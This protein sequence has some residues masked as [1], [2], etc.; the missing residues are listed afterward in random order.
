MRSK[1][2]EGD[3]PVGFLHVCYAL[4]LKDLEMHVITNGWSPSLGYIPHV[5]MTQ[6]TF[7]KYF[8]Q[9]IKREQITLPWVHPYS[10]LACSSHEL[11]N[12]KCN[13]KVPS[14]FSQYPSILIQGDSLRSMILIS[15]KTESYTAVQKSKTVKYVG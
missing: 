6:T 3:S 12:L 13:H 10:N 1:D 9:R 5:Y 14:I 2:W 7:W 4:P 11:Q 15:R 8:C